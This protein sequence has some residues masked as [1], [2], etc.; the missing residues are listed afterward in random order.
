MIYS[1]T[2]VQ[3]RYAKLLS[4]KALRDAMGEAPKD[5]PVLLADGQKIKPSHH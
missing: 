3:P 1:A 4:S 5:E 2:F